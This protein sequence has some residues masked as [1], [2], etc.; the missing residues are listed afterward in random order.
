MTLPAYAARRLLYV[1]PVLLCALALTFVLT[2]VVPG[3]PTELI[4]GPYATPE[5]REVLRHAAHLDEPIHVQFWLYLKGLT[6]GDFG[7][8]YVTG[9]DVASDLTD[10]FPAT[11][12]LVTY[13]MA[14][15]VLLG[16]SLGVLAALRQDTWIDQCIRVVSVLGVAMPLFWIGLVALYV[17]YF[18]LGW[19]PGPVGRTGSTSI[20]VGDRVTGLLLVDSLLRG[21]LSAWWAGVRALILPVATIAFAAMAPITRMARATMLDVLASDH[22]RAARAL[23]LPERE[24]IWRN[25]LRNTLVPVLTVATA[26]YGYALGGLVLVEVV[27]SWPGLGAY[28]YNA[29]INSDFP[30]V[31]GFV[32]LSTALYLLLYLALD[33]VTATID[34][35]TRS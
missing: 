17:F 16:A 5:G 10:R 8:S 34:P 7:V 20:A 9:S 26:V 14:I 27:F 1:L 13:A 22:V 11:F 32:V 24:V 21:D 12:E 28:S 18:E 25:A 4:S 6:H 2:R 19:L 35:R 30:A 31:Q 23:G 3:D 15:A 33:V 29:I